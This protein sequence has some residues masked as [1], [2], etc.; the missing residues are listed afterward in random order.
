MH[1]AKGLRSGLL[2]AG[3]AALVVASCGGQA[4]AQGSFTVDV[5]PGESP[6]AVRAAIPGQET[7]FLVTITD[8]GSASGPATVTATATSAVVDR[9]EPAAIR[10]GQ[11][12]EIWVTIDPS[13][14]T[15]STA[16]VAI[17]V[18]RGGET[19]TV[20]RSIVVMPMSSEGRERDAAPHFQFWTAWLASHHPELGITTATQWRPVFVSTLLVVSHM[21]YF[22]DQWEMGLAWHAGTVPPYDWSQ[23]YLRRRGTE[24]IPSIAFKLDSFSGA[25]APYAVTPPEV[26]VR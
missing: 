19:Q 8:G 22:S 15:D 6:A 4:P 21:S 20:R 26:V 18:S 13:I 1:L 25:T 12:A 3:L 7:S 2:P 5:A 23:I 17:E 11:V 16:G 10:A 14:T 9:V 24:V